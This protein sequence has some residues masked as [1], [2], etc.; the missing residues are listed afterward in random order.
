MLLEV[1]ESRPI[2][3]GP[4]AAIP[5]TLVFL[6]LAMCCLYFVNTLLMSREIVDGCEALRS[7]TSLFSTYVLFV[8]PSC[9]LSK[10]NGQQCSLPAPGQDVH[11]VRLGLT[12]MTTILILT[13]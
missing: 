10:N 4:W 9:M 7:C 6:A 2:L 13:Y 5:E 12:P 1:I 3:F 8:V 11:E